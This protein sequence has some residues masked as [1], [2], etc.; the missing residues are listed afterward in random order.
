[1]N[2]KTVGNSENEV[3]QFNNNLKMKIFKFE[4]N[5]LNSVIQ[6]KNELKN[7][8]FNVSNENK[9]NSKG[10]N[11]IS[12]KSNPKLT[13]M[14]LKNNNNKFNNFNILTNDTI[15]DEVYSRRI[16]KNNINSS[17]SVH[18]LRKTNDFHRR[19]S[20]DMNQSMNKSLYKNDSKLASK[21][22]I[23]PIKIGKN[24]RSA[25][26]TPIK[27]SIKSNRKLY[28]RKNN[29]K[30]FSS[31][32]NLHKHLTQINL[33]S[34]IENP[35]KILHPKREIFHKSI[36]Y[37]KLKEVYLNEFYPFFPQKYTEKVYSFLKRREII[38]NGKYFTE[39][40]LSQTNF[41]DKLKV[42]SRK[43]YITLDEQLILALREINSFN[44]IYS[45]YIKQSNLNFLDK[46]VKE[47]Q[48]KLPNSYN[49][50]IS[51]LI[52]YSEYMNKLKIPINIRGKSNNIKYIRKT[53]NDGDSLYRLFIF[54]ILEFH[55]LKCHIRE[56]QK[57]V[58]DVYKIVQERVKE[59]DKDKDILNSFFKIFC[60]IIQFLEKDNISS[61]HT[62]LVAGFN[63]NDKAF[64]K[65]IIFYV[66][67][68]CYCIAEDYFNEMIET[69]K[70]YGEEINEINL[71]LLM[72]KKNEA[73][74][75]TLQLLPMIFNANIELFI[76]DG[77]IN[78]EFNCDLI[79]RTEKFLS[80]IGE[81][82][83]D[84]KNNS[85]ATLSLQMIY[86]M[87]GYYLGYSF[88]NSSLFE[89]RKYEDIFITDEFQLSIKYSS[90]PCVKCNRNNGKYIEIPFYAIA[91]CYSCTD[92]FIYKVLSNRI[93]MMNKENFHSREFYGR[94]FEINDNA[95]IDDYAHILIFSE[96][97]TSRMKRYIK[98]LCF[99]CDKFNDII[100]K[101]EGCNCQLC[102][103]CIDKMVNNYTHDYI[104]LNKL[105][106]VT[107]PKIKCA[108]SLVFELEKVLPFMNKNLT[109]YYE[110][111]KQ[112][113]SKYIQTLCMSCITILR[114][115]M[116][117][118]KPIKDKNIKQ[119]HINDK[120][121]IVNGDQVGIKINQHLICNN[122][123][124][125]IKQNMN[126]LKENTNG[127]KLLYCKICDIEHIVDK[128]SYKDL[129]MK[130]K[131]SCFI[132]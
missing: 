40:L 109:T 16:L 3:S 2:N 47:I 36:S 32:S 72:N 39:Y 98:N 86:L 8:N 130:D 14:N 85:S 6:I 127:D 1:M 79:E 75:L 107:L 87:N 76:Y 83:D 50:L 51:P 59:L 108:C 121:D 27:R 94:G 90:K 37:I 49:S 115:E 53:Q 131:C 84:Q 125:E 48:H 20:F 45:N 35:V 71:N 97:I 99:S 69:I 66:R 68:V 4:S 57:I 30:I 10:N 46:Y 7:F 112:R 64:D 44:D 21:I 58:L 5:D 102:N 100:Y 122:C 63:S 41:I 38:I 113:Y 56:I 24:N 104:I 34:L 88:N 70:E 132:F 81:I 129:L 128:K 19:L 12:N 105:E 55:I 114:K 65:I 95:I 111:A 117:L 29:D 33:K 54:A 119:I 82:P 91:I 11:I 43:Y 116:S 124:N 123:I 67:Q 28:S 96:S 9:N 73:N 42:I 17:K 62:L 15:D 60:D 13:T 120:V 89:L 23:S 25:V 52:S 26:N 80:I 101:L 61:A 18:F 93:S 78:E 126:Q 92:D 106:K 77:E 74:K 103:D 22:F 118:K 31:K 110:Q